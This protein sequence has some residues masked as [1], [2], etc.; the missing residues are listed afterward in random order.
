VAKNRRI[1]FV[2]V[3]VLACAQGLARA[4]IQVPDGWRVRQVTGGLFSIDGLT[5]DAQ[6]RIYA[7]IEVTGS[8]LRFDEAGKY[9]TFAT[10]LRA[11]EGLY[12]DGRGSLFAC[13]DFVNGRIFRIDVQTGQLTILSQ[14]RFSDMEGVAVDPK[15]GHLFVHVFELDPE[16]GLITAS[17][18]AHARRIRGLKKGQPGVVRLRAGE[19]IPDFM[20]PADWYVTPVANRPVKM[21]TSLVLSADGVLYFATEGR[22]VGRVGGDGSAEMV[23]DMLGTPEGIHFDA[24]GNLYVAEEAA[25]RICVID[26]GYL[27]SRR[28]SDPAP[29]PTAAGP[30]RIFATGLGDIEDALPTPDGRV[31]VSQDGRNALLVIERISK[32]SP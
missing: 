11:V 3:L 23:A 16:S 29:H 28:R 6:G 13:E 1:L 25:G 5:Y 15:T 7:A 9:V 4:E 12:C 27:R 20:N 21:I 17:M 19:K 30:V 24:A 8:I 18:D 14:G 31:Y 10:G 2:S 22:V 32:A 26:A